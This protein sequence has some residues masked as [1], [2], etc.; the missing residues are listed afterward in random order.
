MTPVT[1]L[2]KPTRLTVP[3]NPPAMVVTAV[4]RPEA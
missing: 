4:G 3:I 2:P 1:E